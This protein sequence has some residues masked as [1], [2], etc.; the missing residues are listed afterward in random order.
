[1]CTQ[2]VILDSTLRSSEA[3]EFEEALRSK[4]VS[5]GEAL[6]AMVNLFQVF[7]AGLNPPGR[8]VGSLLFLGP[9]GPGRP[10]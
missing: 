9:Q 5:Q 4:I 6:E 7:S 2:P 1:M 3:T 8:P 10:G